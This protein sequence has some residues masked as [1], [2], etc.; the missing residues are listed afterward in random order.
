MSFY[1]RPDVRHSDPRDRLMSIGDRAYRS[2]VPPEAQQFA[3]EHGLGE[4]NWFIRGADAAPYYPD[5]VREILRKTA[6]LE[7]QSPTNP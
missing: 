5:S 3:Q 6:E 4:C 7:R 1:E 2:E